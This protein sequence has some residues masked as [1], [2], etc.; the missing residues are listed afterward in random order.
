M[1]T[2]VTDAAEQSRFVLSRAFKTSREDIFKAWTEPERLAKWFGPKGF[3]TEGSALDLRP[4]GVYHYSMRSPDGA[5]MWGKW[6]Y[7]EVIVPE[8]L[9]F[10]SSFSDE[11]GGLTRQPF[12]AA[13]PLETLSTVTFTEHEG[14]TLL[15]IE[16]IPLGATDA[17]CKVFAE[18]RDS[19]QQ[20][21]GGTLDQLE[22]YL[23]S[24]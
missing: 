4:G 11:R 18:G 3:T 5:V 23:V 8:K 16:G 7:G 24:E 19:M 1:A 12:A 17:E 14:V 10:V 9:V 15:A 20:G 6:V 13:W 22:Q 21:W 2:A